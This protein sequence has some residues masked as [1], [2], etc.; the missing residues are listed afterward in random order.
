MPKNYPSTRTLADGDG[1]SAVAVTC[2]SGPGDPPFEERHAGTSIAAVLSG[3]FTYRTHRGQALMVPGSLLLGNAGTCFECGHDHGR[4]DRCVAFHFAPELTEEMA[5]GLAGMTRA[6]FT[7]AAIPP[8]D[9]LLPLLARLGALARSPDPGDAEDLA[10]RLVAAALALD[11]GSAAAVQPRDARRVALAVR[12]IEARPS[13][14]WDITG[15]ADA[16]GLRR[17]RFAFVFRQVVGV[18]PYQYLLNRRLDLAAARLLDD[19]SPVLDIALEAGFGDL[20]EFTRRFHQRF[21]RPPGKY[22]QA[23]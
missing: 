21:G 14:A 11:Q 15:L 9:A 12:I 10:Y 1:W 5:A 22:R 6:G 16:V 4:C 17:R 18:T 23:R 8:V 7:R 19:R 20:S 13:E 2:R 3:T